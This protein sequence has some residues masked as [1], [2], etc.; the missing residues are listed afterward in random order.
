MNRYWDGTAGGP[1]CDD[2]ARDHARDHAAHAPRPEPVRPAAADLAGLDG[3]AWEK[4]CAAREARA[5]EGT[6]R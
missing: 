3:T 6:T 2:E 1:L 4:T 5:R